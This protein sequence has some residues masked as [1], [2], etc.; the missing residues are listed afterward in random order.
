MRCAIGNGRDLGSGSEPRG[1]ESDGVGVDEDVDGDGDLDLAVGGEPTEFLSRYFTGSA[2]G[3][4]FS[5]T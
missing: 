4:P 5:T 3:F 2:S 1:A